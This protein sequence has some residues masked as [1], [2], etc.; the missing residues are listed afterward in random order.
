MEVTEKIKYELIAGHEGDYSLVLLSIKPLLIERKRLI[1]RFLSI[2]VGEEK[3]AIKYQIDH[4][5]EKI[6]ETLVL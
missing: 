6:R 1:R 5:E 2:G 3:A 4:W